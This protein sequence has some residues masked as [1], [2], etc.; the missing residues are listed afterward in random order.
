[1][2]EMFLVTYQKKFSQ[3]L[4]VRRYKIKTKSE[5]SNWLDKHRLVKQLV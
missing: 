2:S 3:N 1:M 5:T 4:N